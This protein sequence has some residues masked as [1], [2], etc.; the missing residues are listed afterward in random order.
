MLGTYSYMFRHHVANVR[1]YRKSNMYFRC[2]WPL[3]SSQQQVLKVCSTTVYKLTSPS[4]YCS[5]KNTVQQCA[6]SDTSSQ[7]FVLS[8]LCLDT[9]VTTYV[10]QGSRPAEAYDVWGTGRR[11]GRGACTLRCIVLRLEAIILWMGC[12]RVF[13]RQCILCEIIL[14]HTVSQE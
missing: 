5:D 8:G 7:L 14:A 13:H 10:S 4:P 1:E 3:L 11:V 2:Q 12:Q 9:S 6:S